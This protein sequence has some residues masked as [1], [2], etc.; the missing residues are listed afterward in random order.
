MEIIT[1]R[2]PIEGEIVG[3]G[4]EQ[5]KILT[6]FN[7]DPSTV[8]RDFLLYQ[9]SGNSVRY[10]QLNSDQP[11]DSVDIAVN[12]IDINAISRPLNLKMGTSAS[13]K[14]EFR[15]TNMISYYN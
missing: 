3:D 11:L 12:Y 10:Y 9:P 4:N 2:L 14:L 1:N 13:V 7:I 5:K 6:D 8:V 15:P